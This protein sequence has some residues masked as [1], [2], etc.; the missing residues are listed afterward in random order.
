MSGKP[1]KHIPTA[2]QEFLF[3]S[4]FGW[5]LKEVRKLS[6]KDVKVLLPMVLNKFV[7]DCYKTGL[8]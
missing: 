5:T 4:V 2:V 6:D 7:V 1:V 3:A 8:G